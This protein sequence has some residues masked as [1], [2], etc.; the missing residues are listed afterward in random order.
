MS[1]NP[2]QLGSF[3]TLRDFLILPWHHAWEWYQCGKPAVGFSETNMIGKK[4]REIPGICQRTLCADV[5]VSMHGI[6][7]SEKRPVIVPLT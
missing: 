6:P 7:T 4:R 2:W 1:L 3:G 5:S